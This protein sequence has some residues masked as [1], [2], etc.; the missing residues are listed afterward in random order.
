MSKIGFKLLQTSKDADERQIYVI[1]RHKN[2]DFMRSVGLSILPA[3]FDLKTGRAAGVSNAPEINKTIQALVSDM[4]T[5]A[6]NCEGKGLEPTKPVIQV[7][8]EELL[9][10]A[11]LSTVLKPQTA[12]ILGSALECL[13]EELRGL[14]AAVIA[15]KVAIE[16]EELKQGLFKNMLLADYVDK[17][18]LARKETLAANS[19]RLFPNLKEWIIKFSPLWRIDNITKTTLTEFQNFLIKQ[20]KKSGSIADLVTKLKSVV[21]YYEDELQLDLK[22]FRS[23]KLGFQKKRNDNV[24]YLNKYE[25]QA[26][27][28]LDLSKPTDTITRDV[29]CL[30]SLT[31]L[32]WADCYVKPE[33][34]EKNNLRV[35][36]EKTDTDLLIPISLQAHEILCRLF[37][38]EDYKPLV[39]QHFNE[40]IKNICAL[41]PEI[42]EKKE[43]VKTY[44]GKNKA[45]SKVYKPKPSLIT[46]HT[47]RRTF[48]NLALSKGISPATIASIV[49]HEGTE[50]IMK[51][52]SNKSV[53]IEKI[54]ELLD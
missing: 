19:I 25:L 28:D 2:S 41:V 17:Y 26:L 37:A 9:V 27:L 38:R 53:G 32:R 35:I 44:K 40:R 10:K 36:T 48:I 4:E 21:L 11:S 1:H 51:T 16:S 20:D 30:M 24:I 47:G 6:R 23:F 50:L 34:I 13:Y 49:G 3:H 29:F 46:C 15:K 14:E 22:S 43:L 12:Q 33:Q 54:S 18:I 5:A 31:G 39:S 8:Y 52:Y 45:D 42:A 7:A